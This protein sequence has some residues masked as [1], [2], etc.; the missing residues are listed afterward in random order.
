MFS[1][2]P[3]ETMIKGKYTKAEDR[4]YPTPVDN[5]KLAFHKLDMTVANSRALKSNLA[6]SMQY[7]EYLEKQLSEIEL[8]S[9]L[10]V[11]TV[12]SYVITGM[13]VL[14][15]LFS[16]IVRS[17]GWWKMS[18]TES[19]GMVTA[20][21]KKF[22]EDELIVKTELCKE[23][24]PYEVQMNLDELIKKLEHHHDALGVDHL[25]YPALRRLK[26]LRNRIHLQKL[27]SE[28][29]HDYNAFD[30]TVKKEMGSVLYQILTSR[31]VTDLPHQ[32]DFLKVNDDTAETTA[33]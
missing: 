6:Y 16:N 25:T 18:S 29:D 10:Y 32:F 7:L 24:A 9:V 17:K 22:G 15:G 2:K 11:M 5:Y 8:S 26:E 21:K 20:N 1:D 33:E 14:E 28:T 13:S 31:M 27:E 3:L 19:L 4:W 23:V 30:F 12:K